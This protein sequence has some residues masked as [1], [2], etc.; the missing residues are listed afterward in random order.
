M[1]EPLDFNRLVDEILHKRCTA[2]LGAGA[3]YPILP[4][5]AKLADEV[6]QKWETQRK[7]ASPL[8][9]RADLARVAQFI[10]VADNDGGSPKHKV[11]EY[12][13]QRI[14]DRGPP[15]FRQPDEPHGV[16]AACK[17]PLYITTNYDNFM[18][19]A[20]KEAHV[21]PVLEYARW[22]RHLVDTFPSKLDRGF[23]PTEKTPLVFHLHGHVG[24]PDAMVVSDDDYLDFL[25][26]LSK[27]LAL[28]RNKRAAIVPACVR[29][30]MTEHTLLFIGYSLSDINFRVILRGL[31]GSLERGQRRLHLAV[32]VRGSSD[33]MCAYL[34]EYF[35]WSLDVRVFWG[36]AQEFCG[37]L[38]KR[39]TT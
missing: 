25:V 18:F 39:L 16:L 9:N 26:N 15:D 7:K 23:Q 6:L 2:F 11:A 8:D 14:R 29:R 20:L 36:T 19:Q 5:G 17:L 10:A 3:C 35:R 22:T 1:T 31:L 28:F 24:C 4:L 38:R 33:A 34:E 13:G 12:L 37:E 32:Q 30:A 27:D 21:N